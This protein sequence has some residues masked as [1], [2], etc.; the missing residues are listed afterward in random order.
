MRKSHCIDIV[1][2]QIYTYSITTTYHNDALV[3]LMTPPADQAVKLAASAL[4]TSK[5]TEQS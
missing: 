1:F 4:P 5:Y 3:E 2:V